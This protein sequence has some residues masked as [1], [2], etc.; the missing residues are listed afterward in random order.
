MTLKSPENPVL[1][2][3]WAN[4][5]FL[6]I[7]PMAAMGGVFFLWHQGA[8][9]LETFVFT[10]ILAMISGLSVT[11]GYHRLF[12]HRSYEASWLF[13]LFVLLFGAA[14]FE[15][16]ARKWCSDHRNH[17][18]YVDTD[19][20]PYNIKKG[21]WHA[22]MGWIFWKSDPPPSYSNVPDLMADPLIR[23]QDKYYVWLATFFGFVL[24]MGITSLWN[25]PW[26]GLIFGG[27][28]RVV[29][30]H[31]FTFSINSF[32]HL[33]GKQPYS[34][35]NSSRDS[36][37]LAF[38]TYG[39]GYH[40]FHHAFQADYRNGIRAFHWDPS[41]WFIYF[42]NKIGIATHLKKT[43]EARILAAKLRMDEVR[44]KLKV[45]AGFLLPS[46]VV[47]EEWITTARVRLEEAHQHFLRLKE[48]YT[49]LKKAKLFAV[50][51]KMHWMNEQAT[52][53]KKDLQHAKASFDLAM[54]S[55]GQ[56]CCEA[57]I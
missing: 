27:L 50:H 11:A 40:N 22:H 31:H 3:D 7:T 46:R 47:T 52:R 23:F 21:F 26:G 25:D 48:E 15:N 1:K 53:I 20:D 6:S 29:V 13:R 14:S 24:P 34:D 36:A 38:F 42:M 18:R 57:G 51:E 17:H 56:L 28:C 55:W 39:E 8:F 41:K 33:I 30:N 12:A 37:L 45:Q 32:C 5:L 44:L 9:H 19:N 4:I 54:N 43:S 35:K 16:S 10:F 2:R 49:K